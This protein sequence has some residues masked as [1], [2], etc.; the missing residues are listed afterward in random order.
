MISKGKLSE[1]FLKVYV[2]IGLAALLLGYATATGAAQYWAA[3]PPYNTLWPLWSPLL[4]PIDS[5][6]GLPTPIVTS[7]TTST[8][9]SV[10]PGL[11]WDP[12][13]PYPYL[14]YCSP[15]GMAYFDPY[16]KSVS[17]WPPSYLKNAVGL[18]SP[19]T[20]PAA[21]ELLPPPNPSFLL[22]YVPLANTAASNF[23]ISLGI[24]P[25]ITYLTASALI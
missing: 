1:S 6:T 11:T 2:I 4:S 9:L 14:L 5:A 21:Y 23:L 20:L 3:L 18:P 12:Y 7:L 19:L 10:Q 13:A 15:L 24:V 8:K 17:F 16:W 22:T 25:P